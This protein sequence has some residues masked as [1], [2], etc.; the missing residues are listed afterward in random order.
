MLSHGRF[1]LHYSA[2]S[3]IN[4]ILLRQASF[5]IATIPAQFSQLGSA[6]PF[7]TEAS[8]LGIQIT[9]IPLSLPMS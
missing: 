3:N 6:I 2:K 4:G 7:S 9:K 8:A 5:G 1:T